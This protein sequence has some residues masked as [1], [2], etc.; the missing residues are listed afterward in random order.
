MGPSLLPRWQAQLLL[1]GPFAPSAAAEAARGTPCHATPPR[2]RAGPCPAWD[3]SGRKCPHA[4]AWNSPIAWTGRRG[5]PRGDVRKHANGNGPPGTYSRAA[6]CPHSEHGSKTCQRSNERLCCVVC[7][8]DWRGAQ[9]PG[10]GQHK[11]GQGGARLS[12]VHTS[13]PES[14]GRRAAKAP[15]QRPAQGSG[16]REDQLCPAGPQRPE[17]PRLPQVCE[18][19]HVREPGQWVPQG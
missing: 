11:R 8:A 5:G 1:R 16:G 19:Q 10:S 18:A 12:P 9:P 3:A 15:H 6:P 13:G 4:S 14:K 17:L 2:R 7:G